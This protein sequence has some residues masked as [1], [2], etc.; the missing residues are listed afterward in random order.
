[1]K[2]KDFWLIDTHFEFDV[3]KEY[4]EKKYNIKIKSD[5]A[6]EKVG[7]IKGI[8]AS[9]GKVVGHVKVIMNLDDIHKIS[10]G[11]VLV[12]SMTTPDFIPAMKRAVGFIT[13]EGGMLSHAAIVSREFGKPCIV[14]TK[15]ATQVLKNGDLVEVDGGTGVVRVI[16]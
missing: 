3:S 14:G 8:P 9:K 11:D 1:M 15:I 16:K 4:I 5:T 2:D 13:D 10:D 7:V 6:S 12:T